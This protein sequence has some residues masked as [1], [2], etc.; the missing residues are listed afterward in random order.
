ML[1]IR[2]SPGSQFT[3]SAPLLMIQLFGFEVSTVMAASAEFTAPMAS[4]IQKYDFQKEHINSSCCEFDSIVAESCAADN[5]NRQARRGF[6]VQNK[7]PFSHVTAT[8]DLPRFRL[9]LV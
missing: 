1:K 2:P 4:A 6:A 9:T 7:D 5:D 3:V 8:T